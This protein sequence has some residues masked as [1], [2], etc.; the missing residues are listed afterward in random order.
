MITERI[1]FDNRTHYDHYVLRSIKINSSTK[2]PLYNLYVM[3]HGNVWH[4]P[5]EEM[6]KYIRRR[7]H[8]LLIQSIQEI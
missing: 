7:H 2:S 8:E 6:D 4:N 5:R 1:I 3:C